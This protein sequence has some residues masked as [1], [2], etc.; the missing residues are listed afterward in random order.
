MQHL[1]RE[2]R[3]N[4]FGRNDLKG[5]DSFFKESKG[6]DRSLIK[7]AKQA[8]KRSDVITDWRDLVVKGTCLTL[9]KTYYRLISAPDPMDVRP[10]GVLRQALEF[11][12][13]KWQKKSATYRYID[14][15][16]R[17]I[18]QDMTV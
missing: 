8:S 5:N 13:K 16:L 2:Q 6:K 10:E 12:M 15:Q 17:S 4:A 3:F 7:E 18:R 14:D 9:E 1:L 11:M